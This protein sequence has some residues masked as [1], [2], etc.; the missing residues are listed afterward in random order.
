VAVVDRG[1]NYYHPNLGGDA[2]A[3]TKSPRI[4]N[5]FDYEDN[6]ADPYP[7]TDASKDED[8]L[9]GHGTGVAG[10]LVSPPFEEQN[11]PPSTVT[12]KQQGMLQGALLYNLKEASGPASQNSIKLAMEWVLANRAKY[13]ITAVNLTD[14]IGTSAATPAYDAAAKALWDAGIWVATPVANNWLGDSKKGI[15]PRAPIGYPGKSPWVFAMGGVTGLTT[16]SAETQ[17]GADL[18]L[19]GPAKD[20]TTLY[21]RPIDPNIVTNFATGNSWGVPMATATAVMIQQIDPAVTPAQIMK[22]LQ[23]SGAAV[24]DPDPVSNPDGTI[25]Y[26]RINVLGAIQLAYARRDDA[27]DQGTGN[28]S[29]AAAGTIPLT[30]G[31][32]SASNLKLLMHDHDYYKFTVG[33]AGR[34]DVNIGY[35]NASAFPGGELL[36]AGGGLVGKIGPGGLTGRALSAGDYFVHLFTPGEGLR[37]TYSI[38]IA[39][40]GAA[41]SPGAIGQ[42]GSYNG[43]A[44]DADDRLNF[45]WFDESTDTLKFATRSAAGAWSGVTTIDSTAGAGQHVSL[46][47]DK[48]GRPGVAYYASATGDL[49]YAHFNGSSWDVQTV[50]SRMTT[51]QF[52]SLQFTGANRPVISYYHASGGDLRLAALGA[53]GWKISAIDT[54]GDVGRYSSLALNPATG[55]WAVAYEATGVGGVKYASQNKNGTWSTTLVDQ[56][57]AAGGGPVSLAF[58]KDKLPAFSYYA[59]KTADLRLARLSGGRWRVQAVAA[60]GSTGTFGNLFFNPAARFSPV[61]YYYNQG[62]NKLSVARGNASYVFSLSAIQAGG[63]RY[64]HVALDSNNDETFVWLDTASGDLKVSG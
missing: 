16:M 32:G 5:V 55:R 54:A 40:S 48:S 45:A 62:V 42:N 60:K 8:K 23:D 53:S 17:R 28:D 21:Y 2:A 1:I 41:A 61:V 27:F 14:F 18:D 25:S 58:G 44:F 6:D 31:K 12:Y 37:G 64:N 57:G 50:S 7:E 13:N 63:G 49:K 51:G 38:A 26:Q 3:Q 22:I 46:K 36:N 43:I 10:L 52:P 47:L 24:A 39:R 11:D 9:A 33:R 59:A 30:S 34:Y 35:A 19:L 29:L 20:V 15:P 4:V 56:P